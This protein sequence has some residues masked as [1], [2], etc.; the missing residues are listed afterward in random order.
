MEKK[1]ML[2]G[3]M[4]ILCFSFISANYVEV[5]CPVL[6]NNTTYADEG[7]Y[8]IGWTSNYLYANPDEKLDLGLED[9]GRT[10]KIVYNGTETCRKI[11][12]INNSGN[13]SVELLEIMSVSSDETSPWA[14]AE[15]YLYGDNF[16]EIVS[17]PVYGNSSNLTNLTIVNGM[18]IVAYG[19]PTLALWGSPQVNSSFYEDKVIKMDYDNGFSECRKI[20]EFISCGF[21]GACWINV[22]GKSYEGVP[23]GIGGNYSI[24]YY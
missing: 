1:Y 8:F 11:I 18:F 19:Y 16:Q 20:D 12:E 6:S 7:T 3:L 15:V 10:I 17:C 2:F 9:I 13:N 22:F 24:S 21:W 5:E 23:N 4:V 14:S